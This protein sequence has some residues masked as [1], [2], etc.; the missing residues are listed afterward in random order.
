MI[1][2]KIQIAKV[3]SIQEVCTRSHGSHWLF[4]AR[5]GKL[6]S[7]TLTS[8]AQR[9]RNARPVAHCWTRFGAACDVVSGYLRW[10][11]SH[12]VGNERCE[13]HLYC[14]SILGQL[15]M[16]NFGGS[17]S[18]QENIY[19]HIFSLFHCSSATWRWRWPK[20]IK[21]GPLWPWQTYQGSRGRLAGA[22]ESSG[23]PNTGGPCEPSCPRKEV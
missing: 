20:G 18:W 10:S 4:L 17:K 9:W 22:G 8:K 12:P 14:W 13:W 5:W 7:R 21:S 3:K 2:K 6:M 16:V 1:W 11:T 19:F 15:G 23:Q